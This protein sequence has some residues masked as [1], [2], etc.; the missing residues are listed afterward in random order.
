MIVSVNK[1]V[2][3]PHVVHYRGKEYVFAPSCEVPDDYGQALLANQGQNFF[4]PKGKHVGLAGYTF[5]DAFKTKTLAEVVATLTDEDKL[6]VYELARSLSPLAKP[7]PE[8]D[9]KGKSEGAGKGE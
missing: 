9:K 8:S 7:L 2:Q 4:D 3:L 6:K 5:R 1:S